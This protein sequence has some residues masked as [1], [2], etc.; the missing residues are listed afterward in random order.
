MGWDFSLIEGSKRY[1]DM[2]LFLYPEINGTSYLEEFYEADGKAQVEIYFSWAR[3][4]MADAVAANDVPIYWSVRAKSSRFKSETA[5]FQQEP[6]DT[7]KNFLTYYTWPQDTHT[8]RYLDWFQL[9][10]IN[11]RF[12]EFAKALGWAPSAL[13]PTCPLGN[14]IRNRSQ[15][16]RPILKREIRN[17]SD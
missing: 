6:F 11:N 4:N 2:D 7:R 8:G 1:E 14:I 9:P 12:P 17:E 10:V 5:P 3:L 13:Q 16:Y 15:E